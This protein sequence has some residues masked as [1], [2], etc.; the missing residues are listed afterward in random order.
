[1]KKL[2][3]GEL[4]KN[5]REQLGISQR[6]LS[7]QTGIDN[8]TIAK[9]ERNIRKKPN[10]LILKKI[11]FIL[12]IEVKPLL[13]AAGYSAEDIKFELSAIGYDMAVRAEDGSIILMEELTQ[14][15]SEELL[16]DKVICELIDNCDLDSLKIAKNFSDTEK[17]IV[18]KGFEIFKNKTISKE[19]ELNKKK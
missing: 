4:I 12:G 19:K 7:R 15:K 6:E 3:L 13:K 16:T 17:R 2:T 5:A 18:K 10:V 11:A 8:N 1:M 14:R 9:I